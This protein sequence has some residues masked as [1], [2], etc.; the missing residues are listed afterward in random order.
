MI[1]IMTLQEGNLI[2]IYFINLHR[3]QTN[4]DRY[5]ISPEDDQ[6]QMFDTLSFQNIDAFSASKN[7]VENNPDADSG[8]FSTSQA[9]PR[10]QNLQ[11]MSASSV[12]NDDDDEG[13]S[14]LAKIKED[15]QEE[16]DDSNSFDQKSQKS[17]SRG[18]K[19]NRKNSKSINKIKNLAPIQIPQT[20]HFGEGKIQ[21]NISFKGSPKVTDSEKKKTLNTKANPLLGANKIKDRPLKLDISFGGGENDTSYSPSYNIDSSYEKNQKKY[22]SREENK[23]TENRENESEDDSSSEYSQVGMISPKFC[24]INKKH[25]NYLNRNNKNGIDKKSKIEDFEN[26][27][28]RNLFHTRRSTDESG[29]NL[30]SEIDNQKEFSF[31]Y[32]KKKPQINYR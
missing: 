4:T 2:F 16:E 19:A 25:F 12:E 11:E 24:E 5:E 1:Q 14:M 31:N 28:Y 3:R 20:F 13:D 7:S 22:F 29:G 9:S 32:S 23:K 21:G 18:K 6:N 26:K 15:S 27:K 17:Q 30:N 10:L 8:R